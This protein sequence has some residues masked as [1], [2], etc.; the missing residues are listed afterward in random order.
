M[1]PSPLNVSMAEMRGQLKYVWQYHNHILTL[2]GKV[3][4]FCTPDKFIKFEI[5]DTFLAFTCATLH[6]I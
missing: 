6:L 4:V 5:L 1:Q 2:T 3:R